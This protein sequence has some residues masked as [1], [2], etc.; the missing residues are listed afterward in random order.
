VELTVLKSRK[1]L[2]QENQGK[3]GASSLEKSSKQNSSWI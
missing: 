3:F 2:K 1:H